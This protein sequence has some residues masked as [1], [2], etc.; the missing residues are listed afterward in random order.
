MLKMTVLVAKLLSLGVL[1]SF[2]WRSDRV[3]AQ[4]G[5]ASDAYSCSA[6]C[7]VFYYSCVQNGG[8]STGGC[9]YQ[10]GSCSLG[11]CYS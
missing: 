3:L 1:A 8:Q 11:G 7:V 6:C 10:T 9:D 5:C 4:S 2:A